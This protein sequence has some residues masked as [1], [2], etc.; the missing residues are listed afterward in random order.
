MAFHDNIVTLAAQNEDF[1]HEVVTGAHSQ[2]VL[3]SILPGEEIGE[4]V[5]AHVDQTLVFVAGEG[6]AVLDG[7]SSLVAVNSLY[8]VPAGTRHNFINTGT[9]P[10]K[11][12]TVYAPAEHKPG[13]VFRTKAEA[14]AAEQ[15][16]PEGMSDPT[17]MVGK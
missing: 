12:Y 17:S 2:V 5:H 6:R 14:E 8:F 16:K 1:R 11:L 4:E 13:S 15:P 7:M 3:M 9:A 10:L